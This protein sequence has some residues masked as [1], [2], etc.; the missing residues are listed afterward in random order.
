MNF[1]R[2]PKKAKARE[3][4]LNVVILCRKCSDG[5]DKEQFLINKRPLKGN[6]LLIQYSFFIF[7][8][9][10]FHLVKFSHL[11]IFGIFFT[12]YYLYEVEPFPETGTV[13]IGW[14]AANKYPSLT[15]T[16]VIW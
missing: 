11:H 16:F 2:K 1:P 6:Q 15:K 13:Q 12:I 5:E 8:D 4:T 14:V 10:K 9:Y 7:F 3:E